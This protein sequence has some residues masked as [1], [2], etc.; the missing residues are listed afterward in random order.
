MGITRT[1]FEKLIV[2]LRTEVGL[3]FDD[4]MRF[5]GSPFDAV[6]QSKIDREGKA[7]VLLVGLAADPV[8]QRGASNQTITTTLNIDLI[9]VKAFV[10]GREAY[11]ENCYALDDLSDAVYAAA[12][13]REITSATATSNR[14]VSNIEVLTDPAGEYGARTVPLQLT[15]QRI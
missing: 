13:K 8:A 11:I 9:I 7:A 5:D 6:E 12:N 1:T 3:S 15:V 2:Y 10:G 14:A 4:V